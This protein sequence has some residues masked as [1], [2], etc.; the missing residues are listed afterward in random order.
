[1]VMGTASVHVAPSR[2]G[3]VLHHSNFF[4]DH[5][6]LRKLETLFK[7]LM[8]AITISDNKIKSILGNL[9]LQGLQV[10]SEVGREN[11]HRC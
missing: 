1:M 6:S 9:P 3:A 8:L 4:E 7:T 2:T 5:K 11:L 10:V